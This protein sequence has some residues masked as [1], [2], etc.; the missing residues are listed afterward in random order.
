V[1]DDD[2]KLGAELP[3]DDK[4]SYSSR[5]GDVI[6]G[7]NRAQTESMTVQVQ[8][9][10][11]GYNVVRVSGDLS[12]NE[13]STLHHFVVEELTRTPAHLALDLR[14]VKRIDRAGIEALSAAAGLAANSNTSFCLVAAEADPVATALVAAH[15]RQWF[16]IF[17]SVQEAWDHPR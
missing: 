5:E 10:A 2:R 1:G 8:R 11:S 15:K 7:G 13:G 9:F 14:G 12:G 16:E 17:A 3:N 6:D 4:T